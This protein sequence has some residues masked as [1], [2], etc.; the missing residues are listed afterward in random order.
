M[1]EDTRLRQQETASLRAGIDLGMTLIDTAKMDGDGAT[2]TLLGEALAGPRDEVFL[3]SKVYPQNPGAAA[4]R[5]L[6]RRA[7]RRSIDRR[8]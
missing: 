4:S 1:G 7:C 3:V 6:A 5:R 2:E 8:E